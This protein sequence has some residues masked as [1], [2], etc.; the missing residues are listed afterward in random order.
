MATRCGYDA[1]M[2]LNPLSGAAF[3]KGDRIGDDYE[4][5]DVLGAGGFGIVYLV[6]HRQTKSAYA[7][8]TFRD[9]LLNDARTREQFRKEARIWVELERHPNL[10]RAYQV[11]EFQGRLFVALEYIAPNEDGLNSLDGYLRQSQPELRQSLEWAIQFCD[12]MIH[13]HA[14]GI[15][16]HRDIKPANIMVTQNR[17]LKISDVGLAGV[18]SATPKSQGIIVNVRNN[19]VGMSLLTVEG[20]VGT[21]THMPLEQFA[22]AALCDARSDIYSFGVVLYQMRNRGQLPFLARLPQ[23]NSEKE[24]MRFWVEM[25]KLHAE[26]PVPKLNSRLQ[27]IIQRCLEKDARRRYQT[28]G[29]LREDLAAVLKR[30][31]G[32]IFAPP[33]ARDLEAWE[34]CNKGAAL[35]VLRQD[36]QALVCYDE[37]LRLAPQFADAWNNKGL[38]LRNAGRTEEALVCFEEAIRINPR[39]PQAWI[40]KGN[41]LRDMGRYTDAMSCLDRALN[42]DSSSTSYWLNKGDILLGL[43]R[44]D[45]ASECFT[46]AVRLNPLSAPAWYRQGLYYQS[47]GKMHEAIG[48]FEKSIELHPTDIASWCSKATCLSALS[49]NE[50][51]LEVINGAL[52]VAPLPAFGWFIKAG[53]EEQLNRVS[54]AAKS[55][56]QFLAEAGDSDAEMIEYAKERLGKPR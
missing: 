3:R 18:F 6:Y 51:A 38:S 54:E 20:A 7:L 39:L 10:V 23:G 27:P 9:E 16:C 49:R 30:E 21:P 8:K 28:F 35:A 52:A 44:M 43:G 19:A 1:N 45:E 55:L 50:E 12:G 47:L 25:R 2:S 31:C 41:C 34:L 37:A 32:A 48:C 53:I 24:M 4:V 15:R 46:N 36:E 17:I 26:A 33:P 13:A 40:N 11:T 14:K 22:D 5:R 42:L 29:Q 56:R